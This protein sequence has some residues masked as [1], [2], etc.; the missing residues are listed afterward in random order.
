[1]SILNWYQ[2]ALIGTII[3]TIVAANLVRKRTPVLSL[4][5]VEDK[6]IPVAIVPELKK[7]AAPVTGS[8]KEKIRALDKLF[9][10]NVIS[11]EEYVEL[12]KRALS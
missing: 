8:V 2:L 5:Q 1:M 9:D 7:L 12:R 10:E 4:A 11:V 6:P 3:G